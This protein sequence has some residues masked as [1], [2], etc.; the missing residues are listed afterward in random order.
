MKIYHNPRCRKSRETLSLIKENN[1]EVIV[2]E[3][4]KNPLTKKEIKHLIKLLNIAAYQLIR[5]E[6]KLFKEKYK[7]HN[8]SEQDC[9]DLLCKHPI[10]LQR[11]IVVKD[12]AAVIGRPPINVLD[13][14]NK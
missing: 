14:L 2:V 6:E 7:N 11:P 10:L 13:L 5:I 8:L 3:Y 12:N 4:L 1:Y 9:I